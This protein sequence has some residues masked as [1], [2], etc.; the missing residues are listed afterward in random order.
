MVLKTFDYVLFFENITSKMLH[1]NTDCKPVS[2]KS[3]KYLTGNHVYQ[4]HH[5][6]QD[7][8]Q[9]ALLASVMTMLSGDFINDCLF[10]DIYWIKELKRA[11]SMQTSNIANYILVFIKKNLSLNILLQ[12]PHSSL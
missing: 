3:N 9:A 11:M 4:N 12:L 8:P 1:C 5:C 2:L 6:M 7:D 10:Q